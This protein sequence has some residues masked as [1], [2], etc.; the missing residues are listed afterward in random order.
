ML[1]ANEE[2]K[3]EIGI[4]VFPYFLEWRFMPRKLFDSGTV[5]ISII[6][7]HTALLQSRKTESGASKFP[8]YRSEREGIKLFEKYKGVG[9]K[10]FPRKIACG[11]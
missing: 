8:A 6:R 2:I 7:M 3:E 11:R 1:C 4:N 5:I 10:D 9:E